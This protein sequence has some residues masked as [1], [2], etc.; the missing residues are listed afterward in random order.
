MQGTKL[1][2]ALGFSHPVEI[3]PPEGITFTVEGP[4][5]HVDGIDKEQVGQVAADIR[6]LRPPEPYLGKGVRYQGEFV[7]RKAGK[8]AVRASQLAEGRHR[9]MKDSDNE[10]RGSR[11]HARV[12]KRVS[13]TA[14]EAP[15]LAVFRS[16]T[17]IYAQVID[18]VA[19]DDDRVGVRR[20]G[21]RDEAG[22]R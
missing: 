21:R 8:S 6:K 17:H 13:G 9:R 12:R 15:R 1:V 20:R 19:R 10:R 22:R 14:A 16:L 7:R 2:L 3:D 18:D 4:R 11:R 5:V